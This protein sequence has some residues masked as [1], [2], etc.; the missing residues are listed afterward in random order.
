MQTFMRRIIVLMLS[1]SLAAASGF[2]P[3]HAKAS[4]PAPDLHHA[5]DMARQDHTAAKSLHSHAAAQHHVN[6]DDRSGKHSD[7]PALADHNCCISCSATAAVCALFDVRHD[8]PKARFALPL[9]F[10]L[11]L[12]ALTSIEPPPR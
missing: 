5:R 2:A 12:S 1:L 8:L 4:M 3:R 7:S 10:G 6:N 9:R 11:T